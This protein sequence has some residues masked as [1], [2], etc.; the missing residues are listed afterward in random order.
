MVQGQKLVD[1]DWLQTNFPCMRACPVHT[2]AG[3]Y[4]ALIGEGR[5]EEAYYYARDPNPLASSCGRVCGHPCETACRRGQIDKPVAIRA[6]KRFLTER[7]GPESPHPLPV[8][9][10]P[11]RRLPH[12]VAIIGAGPAGLSAVHD[13]ALM[14]YSV[15]IFEASFA[16][17][18]MLIHGVPEFRLPRS[19]IEAEVCEILA[20]GDVTLRLNQVAGRDYKVTSLFRQGFDAVLIAVGVQSGNGLSIPGADL[21]GVLSGIDF[22]RSV[23]GRRSCGLRPP[24]GAWR[25]S[26][27]FS[28]PGCGFP[29]GTNVIVIGGGDT[30]MDVA[31][32]AAREVLREHGGGSGVAAAAGNLDAAT[33]H[34]G[35]GRIRIVCL[36][37]RHEMPAS[38][39]EIEAAEAEGIVVHT[40]LGPK[41]ILGCN[42]RVV[43][44]ET[45]KTQ[46]VFDP[47]GP[48]PPYVPQKHRGAACLRHR[49]SRRRSGYAFGLLV[50]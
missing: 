10:Q 22:L 48:L 25:A 4:V 11:S 43:G 1:R 15:T 28:G 47:Q 40:G 9:R 7:Y 33:V 2:N 39:E 37:R 42:G 17:G 36:E 21:Q 29:I 35:A 19:V 26:L 23:N 20:A 27:Q 34:H 44:V 16:A 32:A 14:G 24:V 12:K 50:A 6:L 13:L 45:L 38:H 5:F 49:P 46:Q 41:R 8:Y 31:R 18:G 3:H 30:A